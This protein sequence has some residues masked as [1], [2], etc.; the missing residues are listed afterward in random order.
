[1]VEE[2]PLPRNVPESPLAEDVV[3]EWQASDRGYVCEGFMALL[4]LD[5]NKDSIGAIESGA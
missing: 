3:D 2:A 1:M 5:S 4:Y